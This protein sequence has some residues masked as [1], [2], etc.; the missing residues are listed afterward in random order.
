MVTSNECC[1]F[2]YIHI[3]VPVICVLYQLRYRYYFLHVVSHLFVLFFLFIC[4]ASFLHSQPPLESIAGTVIMIDNNSHRIDPSVY[5]AYIPQ[6]VTSITILSPPLCATSNLPTGQLCLD[7]AQELTDY[8]TNKYVNNPDPLAFPNMG[9]TGST[10][11]RLQEGDPPVTSNIVGSSSGM[12]A[13]P[14]T[15]QLLM[16]P[17]NTISC[18]LPALGKIPQPIP[19]NP[20][21]DDPP[22][23]SAVLFD[24][25]ESTA[26]T[27]FFDKVGRCGETPATSPKTCVRVIQLKTIDPP[28]VSAPTTIIAEVDPVVENTADEPAPIA[29][30]KTITGGDAS[31]SYVEAQQSVEPI[32]SEEEAMPTQNVDYVAPSTDPL[33][34]SVQASLPVDQ[35]L[36][37]TDVPEEV[38]ELEK[39][40]DLTVTE[41]P[42]GTTAKATTTA[43]SIDG[44]T[45]NTSPLVVVDDCKCINMG[46]CRS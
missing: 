29:I 1:K 14:M 19:E 20:P 26:A 30:P 36:E 15:A 40:Q 24:V 33:E 13:R 2:V 8:F 18:L 43:T 10:R 4:I 37:E 25:P 6:Q 16:C 21:I 35:V 17:P 32:T 7:Y 22:L 46:I 3:R 28:P 38:K 34:P 31:P 12:F 39:E 44:V 41:D 9:A 23:P 11:R 5:D 42:S 27:V 45:A